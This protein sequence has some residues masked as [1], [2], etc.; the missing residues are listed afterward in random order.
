MMAL[1]AVGALMSL[2]YMFKAYQT[3]GGQKSPERRAARLGE[4]RTESD[5]GAETF[6][7]TQLRIINTTKVLDTMIEGR[8]LL[9]AVSGENLTLRRAECA[10]HEHR[11]RPERR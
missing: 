9:G 2:F 4:D 6:E 10:A 8:F 5:R 7:G 11:R 3:L 1:G